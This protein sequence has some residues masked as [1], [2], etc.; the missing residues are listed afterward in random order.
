MK[1]V[2]AATPAVAIPT[3]EKLK[4]DHQVTLV[5]Q[6]DRPA[7]RGKKMR[8]TEIAEAYPE[9]KKPDS[10]EE[11]REILKS[12]DLLITIGYGRLLSEETLSVP[13]FGGINLH[14]S[15]LPKW[16]GAAPVQRA[17]SNGDKESGVSVFQMDKGMDT[18]PI[19]SQI[20]FQI[21]YGYSSPQLFEDLS[22]IGVSA[23]EEALVAI[24]KGEVPK[25]QIGETSIARKI[26]KEECAIDW[27]K[28]ATKIIQQIKAFAFNPGVT[29]SIRNQQI[30]IVDARISATTL[31]VGELNRNGEVGTGDG[32]IQLLA[33]TPAGKREMST[34]DWLNGFKLQAGERFE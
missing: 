10:E 15:L 7:G 27:N 19:W 26:S 16:R 4:E 8:A 1:L 28:S 23:V 20:P 13:K 29:A 2:I 12:S 6:P 32:A 5:T 34:S 17:I 3:I 18:G 22:R 33:V 31:P 25:P 21:P 24:S 9:A 30:K 14:F 11:L